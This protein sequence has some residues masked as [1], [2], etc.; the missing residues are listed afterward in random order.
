M[1]SANAN[2]T[3]MDFEGVREFVEGKLQRFQGLPPKPG[4]TAVI[5]KMKELIG[6]LAQAQQNL[7]IPD[8]EFEMHEKVTE[9]VERVRPHP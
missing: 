5:Q 1:T 3:T 7:E 2:G 4:I 8:V 6:S 9:A